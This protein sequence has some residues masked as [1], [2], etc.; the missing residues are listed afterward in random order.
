MTSSL[1]LSSI[2]EAAASLTVQLGVFPTEDISQNIL[3][4]ERPNSAAAAA[5]VILALQL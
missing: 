3:I 4:N 2:T 1:K 5:T